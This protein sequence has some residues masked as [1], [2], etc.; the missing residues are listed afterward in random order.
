MQVECKELH[1]FAN[2]IGPF[3][4][5]HMRSH[6]GSSTLYLRRSIKVMYQGFHAIREQNFAMLSITLLSHSLCPTSLPPSVAGFTK[7]TTSFAEENDFQDSSIQGKLCF[8]L[9]SITAVSIS[10]TM[11]PL[12]RINHYPPA[13]LTDGLEFRIQVG[14]GLANV[15]NIPEYH[16]PCVSVSWYLRKCPV[17]G[18]V[19]V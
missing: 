17:W 10:P 14:E 12:I 1:Q 3:K 19:R 5:A 15:T 4:C 16:V 2:S 8:V 7:P 13:V 11:Y 9:Y 18:V 6:Q